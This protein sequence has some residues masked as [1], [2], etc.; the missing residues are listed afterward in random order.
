[1]SSTNPD[2]D[3]VLQ[4]VPPLLQD[5]DFQL[6]GWKLEE[7]K[8]GIL[9]KKETHHIGRSLDN[10]TEIREEVRVGWT[11]ARTNVINI[12]KIAI[13]MTFLMLLNYYTVFLGYGNVSSS[14][15]IL[16]TTFLSGI[17]LYFSTEKPAPL[18]ITTIDL[19]F[20]YY[21]IQVG[22]L[23]MVTAISGLIG[24]GAFNISMLLLKIIMP[25]SVLTGIFILFKRIKSVRLRP[26][27]D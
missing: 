17:A 22:V 2:K 6:D 5:L 3:G 26:R 1:M 18:R 24:E 27:I 20:I 23:V 4:P 14:V 8:S 16:T 19:I 21:Y 10:R 7:N 11:L 12:M 9:R 25:V 13:P 15:G